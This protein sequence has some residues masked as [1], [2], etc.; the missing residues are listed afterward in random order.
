MRGISIS[1]LGSKASFHDLATSKLFGVNAERNYASSFEEIC[2]TVAMN[3]SDYGVMAV[4]NS[5]YGCIYSNYELIKRF[6][7]KIIDEV[8]MPISMNLYALDE[9]KLE[10]IET[11]ISHPIALEQ[12][13][14]L[15]ASL[16]N[17]KVIEHSDTAS[18]ATLLKEINN[19]KV[20]IIA[21]EE[22]G[23]EYGLTAVATDIQNE[24]GVC[25][26]FVVLSKG[27]LHFEVMHKVVIHIEG[28][29]TG[30]SEEEV[31]NSL[32]ETGVKIVWN[33]KEVNLEERVIE[34]T[35]EQGINIPK[36]IKLLSDKLCNMTILGGFPIENEI[37]ET[38]RF[39]MSVNGVL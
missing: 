17:V 7:L 23:K 30:F 9:V 33:K 20:A 1:M 16:S 25:T 2:A 13:S 32:L 10:E 8:I 36:L 38:G 18:S 35:S 3:K 34:L 19:S 26:S 14:N 37:V 29:Q 4:D 6:Q 27:D 22:V 15:I 11:V 39:E 24:K 31:R 5:N 12:C 28:I 21:G